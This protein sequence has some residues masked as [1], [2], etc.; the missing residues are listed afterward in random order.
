M[1]FIILTVGVYCQQRIGWSQV[2]IF[3]LLTSGTACAS[4]VPAIKMSAKANGELSQGIFKLL[5]DRYANVNSCSPLFKSLR[6]SHRDQLLTLV[7]I[8]GN[9]SAS[10]K[11]KNKTIETRQ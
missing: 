6:R 4:Q 8:S 5:G 7:Y 10:Q 11:T 9:R 2:H 1:L 3:R